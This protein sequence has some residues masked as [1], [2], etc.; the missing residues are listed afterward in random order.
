MRARAPADL[1]EDER[2]IWN[3][4]VATKPASWFGEDTHE[5]LRAYCKHVMAAGVIDRQIEAVKPELL[6][7]AGRLKQY[8]LLL[9]MRDK[10]T[11]AITMLARS[12]RLTQQSQYQPVTAA[13]KTTPGGAKPW[14]E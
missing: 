6:C 14:E 3:T 5:L 1:S 10:Q 9:D 12:M 13:R 2:R 4:V 7:Y 11:R 8:R